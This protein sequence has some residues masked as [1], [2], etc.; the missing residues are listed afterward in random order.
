MKKTPDE[1]IT[2][3]FKNRMSHNL[4]ICLK[5]ELP[6]YKYYKAI[7]KYFHFVPCALNIFSQCS[8]ERIIHFFARDKK[9]I[10][11]KK[12]KHEK[13][14]NF[15]WKW[16][17]SRWLLWS[18]VKVNNIKSTYMFSHDVNVLVMPKV[19]SYP[20]RKMANKTMQLAANNS[21]FTGKM[22]IFKLVLNLAT[23]LF[24]VLAKLLAMRS[25]TSWS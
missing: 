20:V 17:I 6:T 11:K 25:M 5:W 3:V 16:W 1:W 18:F 23:L 2:T 7:D 13:G 19:G 10:P 14:S 15:S 24:H 9:R 12:W 22:P 21:Y 4:Q 8:S